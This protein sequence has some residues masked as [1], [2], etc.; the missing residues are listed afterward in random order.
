MPPRACAAAILA[1]VLATPAAAAPV[2]YI[3]SAV[4]DDGTLNGTPI[5]GQTLVLYGRGDTT[6]I[7]GGT[8]TYE[9]SLSSVS[10]TL[11][12]GFSGDLS[13]SLFAFNDPL[14]TLFGISVTGAG[15]VLDLLAP[16]LAGY[17]LGF[18]D[19]IAGTPLLSPGIAFTTTVGDLVL[20]QASSG[21]LRAVPEPASVGLVGA[22]LIALY[23]V[24]RRRGARARP[25]SKL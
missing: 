6:G 11:S 21:T 23:V 14:T 3:E 10:F 2:T 1:L 18:L 19:P 15:D 4:I 20:N 16:E 24:V 7:V 13:G 22:G 25:P 5:N 8:P 12:G 17:A 9:V